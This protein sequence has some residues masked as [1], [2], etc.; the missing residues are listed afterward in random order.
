MARNFVQIL[1]AAS[2]LLPIFSA[3]LQTRHV[4]IPYY[5]MGSMLL[6]GNL[7]PIGSGFVFEDTHHLVTA[8]HVVFD[9]RGVARDLV[10]EPVKNAEGDSQP[11][12]FD[13]KVDRVFQSL[14]LAMLDIIEPSPCKHPLTRG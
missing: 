2:C 4:S 14:D 8:R 10:F 6:R 7:Q 9:E 3:G 1:A 11:P 13:L 5:S 12:V